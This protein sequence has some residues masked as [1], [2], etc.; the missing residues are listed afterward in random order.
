MRINRLRYL[1]QECN[2][3]STLLTLVTLIFLSACGIKGDLYQTPDEAVIPNDKV[4]EQGDE[5]KEEEI[6]T[7][8]AS[9][10]QVKEQQ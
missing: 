9:Q 7:G 2:I 6:N 1:H 5:N 8:V 10:E 3:K 4:A